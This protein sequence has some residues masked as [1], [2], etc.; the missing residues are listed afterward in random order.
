MVLMWTAQEVVDQW[1]S[2]HAN[3]DYSNPEHNSGQMTLMTI[4]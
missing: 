2:E 4:V 3:F 1:Y